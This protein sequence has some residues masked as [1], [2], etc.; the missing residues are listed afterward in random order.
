MCRGI[1]E[2]KPMFAIGER[3]AYHSLNF[4]YINGEILRRVDGRPIGQFL[5][6]E[7]CK[8]LGIRGAYLGV[9]DSE[10]HRMAVLTDAPPA[11]AEYDARMVGEPA[12]SHRGQGLQQTRGVAGRDSRLGRRVQRSRPRAALRHVGQLGRS[13]TAC[14]CCPRR[15]FAQASS[16]RATSGT[17]SIGSACGVRSATGAR[18]TPVPLA[19][20][21]AFGHVGGR[22]LVRLRRPCAQAG[23]RLR[24]ELL[25]VPKRRR[26]ESRQAAAH[27]VRR[28]HRSRLRRPRS[29]ENLEEKDLSRR[30]EG[31]RGR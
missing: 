22:R 12:G 9:P 16:C 18:A 14:A 24:E 23:Y 25:H 1:A 4:G 17:R 6:E 13:S 3:T 30:R 29:E 19:S 27:A 11:P 20:P 5:E 15:A 28:G 26:R 8:P 31:A 2:L 10:L 21:E 7:I